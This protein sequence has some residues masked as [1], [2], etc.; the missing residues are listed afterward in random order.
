M[1]PEEQALVVAGLKTVAAGEE[2]TPAQVL[3]VERWPI[4]RN[5]EAD[6]AIWAQLSKA[7]LRAIASFPLPDE[8]D[9]PPGERP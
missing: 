2:A 3:A 5:P 9:V 8:E 7:E 4:G 6:A 1:D